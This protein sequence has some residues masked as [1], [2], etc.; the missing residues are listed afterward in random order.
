M[1]SQKEGLW[2][3][4]ELPIGLIRD[5]LP[6]PTASVDSGKSQC[7]PEPP[8]HTHT[9]APP[10]TMATAVTSPGSLPA[11]LRRRQPAS[12]PAGLFLAAACLPLPWVLHWD[13]LKPVL[14][15]AGPDH[16]RAQGGLPS[17]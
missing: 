11:R 14:G 3:K 12:A 2:L 5:S 13:L 1:P 4:G 6:A 17:L 8:P 10:K 7:P 15:R 16:P 9:E